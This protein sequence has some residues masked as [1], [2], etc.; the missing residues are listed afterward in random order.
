LKRECERAELWRGLDEQQER[1]LQI[2]GEASRN[3]KNLQE[4]G[5]PPQPTS[6]QTAFPEQPNPEL[7]GASSNT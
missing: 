6:T 2:L 3:Q 1:R 5:E 4:R 7:S